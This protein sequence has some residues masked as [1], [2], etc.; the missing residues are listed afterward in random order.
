MVDKSIIGREYPAFT[1]EVEK[2]KIRE[3]ARAI[4]DKNPL[5]YDEKAA[6]EAGFEG[7]AIPPSFPTVFAMAGGLMEVMLGDLKLDLAKILHGGQQYEYFKP[8]K[9]GDT[10]T[11]KVRIANAFAKS[12]KGGTM[13]FIVME[14]TYTNQNGEKVLV[15]TSTMIQRR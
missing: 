5:Y 3:F 1:F 11:G 9:P 4:G 10:V 7:I 8:I 15:D 12:G 13:D 2:G 6:K 14:T